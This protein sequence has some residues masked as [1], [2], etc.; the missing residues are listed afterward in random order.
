MTTAIEYALMAG[1]SYISTRPDINKFPVPQGWI[2]VTNPDSYFRD[3]VSGFEAISFT[4]GT[5]LIISYAGTNPN[6]LLDPDNAA[7]IGLATGNG[8]AQL[9]QAAEY[10]LQVKA[11]NPSANITFTGHSLGGGLA[12]LIGVFFGVQAVTFDQAPFA[13]SAQLG[14]PPDVAANLK[15]DLLASGH[16]AAELSELS[17]FLQLRKTNGGIP[18]SSL[19]STIRVDGEF[20][21]EAPIGAFN[22]IG[23]PATVLQHGPYFAPSIDLH[24]QSLLTAFLQSD[25]TAA[26]VAGQ[27]QNFNEVTKKLTDLL[28]MIFNSDLYSFPTA[29]TNTKNENFL[30]RLVKDEAGVRDP[31]TGTTQ[32]PADAMLDRFTRD[33]WKLAQAGGLTLVDDPATGTNWLSRA[34]MLFAM[35]KYYDETA[36]SA[37]YQQEL[38][39]YINGTGGGIRFDITGVAPS[40]DKT[41]DATTAT[42]DNFRVFL[43]EYY[44]RVDASGA[45]TLGPDRDVILAALPALRDWYVQAGTTALNASD[46]FNRGAANDDHYAMQQTRRA[47]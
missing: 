4:N 24:S 37:G 33:L 29:I 36:S 14:L 40:W 15:S 23:T 46:S 7:N 27:K 25:A 43:K 31:V 2:K 1:A 45:P 6:N 39:S 22:P 20:L 10:Y 12:A 42:A 5:D 34:L 41:K 44:T 38:F 8:S 26:T 35:Q 11:A 17:N 9:L 28:G 16:T 19:V 30:E 32:L 18:N 13:K 21:S 3:P 47:A